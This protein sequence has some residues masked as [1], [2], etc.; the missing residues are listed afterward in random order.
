MKNIIWVGLFLIACYKPA[1]TE[2]QP[3]SAPSANITPTIPTDDPI[4]PPTKILQRCK[5]PSYPKN[6]G[7]QGKVVMRITINTEGVV[8]SVLVTEGDQAFI[9]E[10]SRY[11]LNCAYTPAT[12]NGQPIEVTKTEVVTFK[13]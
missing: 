2:K 4:T 12:S 1:N 11:L 3:T 8:T 10:A 5:P 13:R 7:K 6:G 9:P